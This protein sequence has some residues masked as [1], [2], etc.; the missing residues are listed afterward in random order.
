MRYN[1]NFWDIENHEP[2]ESWEVRGNGITRR[3]ILD[4]VRNVYFFARHTHSRSIRAEIMPNMPCS[5]PVLVTLATEPEHNCRRLYLGNSGRLPEMVR[6][7]SL[8]RE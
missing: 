6:E 8:D 5:T 4:V 7:W 3:D 1:I 2:L